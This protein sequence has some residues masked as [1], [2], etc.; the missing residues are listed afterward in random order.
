MS[1]KGHAKTLWVFS[2]LKEPHNPKGLYRVRI[3]A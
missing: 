2:P 3:T 1:W